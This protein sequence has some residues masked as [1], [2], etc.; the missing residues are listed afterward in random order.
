MYKSFS[1]HDP[2]FVAKTS[3][4][5]PAPVLF[6]AMMSSTSDPADAC[7]LTRDLAVFVSN[8]GGPPGAEVVVNGTI[9]YLDAGGTLP[10][11]GDGDFYSVR[12]DG[13]SVGVSVSVLNDGVV[14]G[15]ASL[16]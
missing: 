7:S 15:V 13:S 3:G 4:I 12:V 1:F 8:V 16:C 11:F 9:I 6:G 10:F 2:A 5:G 14:S